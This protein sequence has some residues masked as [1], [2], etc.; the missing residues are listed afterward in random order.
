MNNLINFFDECQNELI[1]ELEQPTVN[2]GICSEQTANIPD[3]TNIN[4][5][6]HLY[7]G[8]IKCYSKK[9]FKFKELRKLFESNNVLEYNKLCEEMQFEKYVEHYLTDLNVSDTK[10]DN[11]PYIKNGVFTQKNNLELI[12]HENHGQ[13]KEDFAY[14]LIYNDTTTA[15]RICE[16][17]DIINKTNLDIPLKEKLIKEFTELYQSEHDKINKCVV[18]KMIELNF[19]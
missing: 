5:F 4:D 11:L 7:L 13:N 16:M 14:A 12:M 1:Q 9:L 3:N 15:N 8:Y 19:I 6:D 18:D 10:I 2:Y 17:T